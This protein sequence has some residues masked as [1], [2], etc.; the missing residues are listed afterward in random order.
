MSERDLTIKDRLEDSVEGT[1]LSYSSHHTQ[2]PL[3][4]NNKIPKR[5]SISG[6]IH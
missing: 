1:D 3:T 4:F 2:V 6:F 5:P